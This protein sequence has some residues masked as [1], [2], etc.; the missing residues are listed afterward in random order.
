MTSLS[1]GCHN[2]NAEKADGLPDTYGDPTLSRRSSSGCAQSSPDRAEGRIEKLGTP[3]LGSTEEIAPP[4]P[5]ARLGK[6]RIRREIRRDIEKGMP[7]IYSVMMP[8]G[9]ILPK[10]TRYLFRRNQHHH[11][12]RRSVQLFEKLMGCGPEFFERRHSICLGRCSPQLR[13]TY[14]SMSGVP[15]ATAIPKSR[16]A[17][18]FIS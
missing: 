3:I 7:S 17:G 15:R 13:N 10:R 2:D 4:F 9:S 1:V 18:K 5:S 14:F 11:F 16:T 6:R 8:L 12:Y